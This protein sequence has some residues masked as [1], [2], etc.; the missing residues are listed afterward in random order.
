MN[1]IS[2][3]FISV[4]VIYS[5]IQIL[6]FIGI[7]SENYSIYISYFLLLFLCTILFPTTYS[8]LKNE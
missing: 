5:L 7:S 1:K 2:I 3:L 8:N 6:N 4:V